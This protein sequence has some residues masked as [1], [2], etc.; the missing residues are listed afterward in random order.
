MYILQEP[1]MYFF[2]FFFFTIRTQNVA[3]LRELSLHNGNFIS[4]CI[5][6]YLFHLKIKGQPG[7]HVFNNASFEEKEHT[8]EMKIFVCIFGLCNAAQTF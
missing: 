8:E 5:I 3:S 6:V 7:K 4:V 1:K 2:F